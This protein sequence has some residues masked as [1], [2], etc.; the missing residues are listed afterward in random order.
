MDSV[1]VRPDMGQ[2]AEHLCC[3][4]DP[5][6]S[7]SNLHPPHPSEFLKMVEVWRDVLLDSVE[8]S[9]SATGLPNGEEFPESTDINES[10][11]PLPYP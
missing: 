5:F 6:S 2:E 10:S 1:G 3:V 4:S 8:V 9:Q 7:P 11:L